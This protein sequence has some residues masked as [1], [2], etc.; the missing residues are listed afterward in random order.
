MPLFYGWKEVEFN[1][2]K[3]AE[4]TMENLFCFDGVVSK[5]C[6]FMDIKIGMS[7]LTLNGKSKGEEFIAGR[8]AKDAATTTSTL[9]FTICGYMIKDKN[10]A[11]VEAG[12][13]THK[14]IQEDK[15]CE[16]LKKILVGLDGEIDQEL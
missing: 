6:S 12:F 15:V 5:A 13:K 4:I 11:K 7:T 1:G 8:A 3:K 14:L 9:G 16:T 10:G 2:K